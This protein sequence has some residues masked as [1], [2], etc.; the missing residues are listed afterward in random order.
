[1][2]IVKAYGG[3]AVERDGAMSY[4]VLLGLLVFHF[5]GFS[6]L[7][8]SSTEES[9]PECKVRL[10]KVGLD[11]IRLMMD[12]MTI[13]MRYYDPFS[14]FL[15]IYPHLLDDIVA[16]EDLKRIPREAVSTMII[17]YSQESTFC[18]IQ[19]PKSHDLPV[20]M[21]EKVKNS[22]P[23]LGDMPVS[24]YEMVA[25]RVSSKKPSIGWL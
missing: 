17:H 13:T 21:F 9:V 1:M 22:M 3:N 25:P 12:V 18:T 5:L 11:S 24:S 6:L 2:Q 23:S 7:G 15:I 19:Y 10:R 20:F 8:K 16:K 14:L 4:L